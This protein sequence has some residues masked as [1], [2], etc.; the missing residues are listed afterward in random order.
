MALVLH[1]YMKNGKAQ[2]S[3]TEIYKWNNVL[4]TTFKMESTPALWLGQPNYPKSPSEM[5]E[6]FLKKV[7]GADPP[8]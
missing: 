2:P 1:L 7:Y 3:L 6:D 8:T 4:T 5:G